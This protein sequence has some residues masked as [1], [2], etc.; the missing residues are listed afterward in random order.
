MRVGRCLACK[1]QQNW[2]LTQS[3]WVQ[4]WDTQ[5]F[6]QGDLAKA[7]RTKAV[8]SSVRQHLENL[9]SLVKMKMNLQWME[10]RQGGHE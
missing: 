3:V 10:V 8:R 6:L 4:L 5:A 9:P 1:T 2:H 7:G